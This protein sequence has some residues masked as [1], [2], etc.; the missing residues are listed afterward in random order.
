MSLPVVPFPAHQESIVGYLWR[1]SGDNGYPTLWDCAK[2]EGWPVK[3]NFPHHT[4]FNKLIYS[5]ESSTGHDAE[6]LNTALKQQH[7]VVRRHTALDFDDVLQD[8][9]LATPRICPD[10]IEQYGYM[11]GS[12]D[13]I[14]MRICPIHEKSIIE[15]C[16]KC[17]TPLEWHSKVDTCC[18]NCGVEWRELLRP[19]KAISNLQM[20]WMQITP[21]K[22]HDWK[23][24]AG[25]Y[26]LKAMRPN[27]LMLH[28][29]VQQLRGNLTHLDRYFDL[30]DS[31]YTI[32]QSSSSIGFGQFDDFSGLNLSA[33]PL[34]ESHG[35]IDSNFSTEC[36][37]ALPSFLIKN[38]KP[39]MVKWLVDSESVIKLLKIDFMFPL[40][41]E[42]SCKDDW[43]N[44]NRKASYEIIQ[45]LG[46]K[47]VVD[48]VRVVRYRYDVRHLKQLVDTVPIRTPSRELMQVNHD[49]EYLK[50]YGLTIIDMVKDALLG[51]IK[52]FR[53]AAGI[54]RL[55]VN[56]QDFERW[57]ELK[58]I[59]KCN[60]P[61]EQLDL[62]RMTG[63]HWMRLRSFIHAGCLRTVKSSSTNTIMYD[64]QSVYFFVKANI[65]YILKRNEVPLPEAGFN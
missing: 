2:A 57:L 60:K 1:L 34:T 54:D 28:K 14:T 25:M 55:L 24:K 5:L 45:E 59:E 32:S 38:H 37:L 51:K 6:L 40:I 41:D 44:M 27:D 18:H 61:V 9:T 30:A 12:F 8:W 3:A 16:P 11:H 46:L 7:H 23:R 15:C 53:Y 29:P 36:D 26:L 58:F 52:A 13:E 22:T 56:Q 48:E 17:H 64:G 35:F 31:L 19:V 21:S 4:D 47:P 63:I 42:K 49:N 33:L 65:D 20:E 43:I 10:C 39:K 50:A 62:H